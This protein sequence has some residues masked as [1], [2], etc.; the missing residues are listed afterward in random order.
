MN[1]IISIRHT[2]DLVGLSNRD[3]L[4]AVLVGRLDR[5]ADS[6]GGYVVAREIRFE[7]SLDF[8]RG[9]YIFTVTA[10]LHPWTSIVRSLESNVY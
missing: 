10:P 5:M 9:G 3:A 1:E 4:A 2:P 8:E 7:R 6:R